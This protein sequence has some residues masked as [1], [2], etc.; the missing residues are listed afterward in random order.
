MAQTSPGAQARG[1]LERDRARLREGARLDEPQR[2]QSPG[3]LRR[4]RSHLQAAGVVVV[5][6]SDKLLLAHPE[7]APGLCARDRRYQLKVVGGRDA[8]GQG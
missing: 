4:Q 8:A 2:R 1:A 3:D 5:A 7:D 6:V